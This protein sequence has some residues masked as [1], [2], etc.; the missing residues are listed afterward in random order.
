[1][2]FATKAD[3]NSISDFMESALSVGILECVLL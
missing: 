3:V 2:Y 1:M